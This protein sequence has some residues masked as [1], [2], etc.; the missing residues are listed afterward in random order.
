[1]SFRCLLVIPSYQE[2]E[3]LPRFLPALLEE[4]S[5]GNCTCDVRVVDDGSGPPHVENLK[6][7]CS[8]LQSRYSMLLNPLLLPQ[9]QGKGGAVRA[10]WKERADYS[11]VGFV[12]ADGAIPPREVIRLV[13][14]ARAHP[15]VS[16]MGSR[17]KMLG[18][19]IQ[20]STTRH[21]SGRVFASLVGVTI[22][23][24]VYDSQ[25]GIKLFPSK[26]LAA[27]EPWL[28]E[29]GFAFDVELLAA[30]LSAGAEIREEPIDWFDIPGSKVS[31]IR[32]VMRM[33]AAVLRIRERRKSWQKGS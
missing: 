29:S 19:T 21:L 28:H 25:C 4:L 32:D 26:V 8:D 27:I 24:D 17:I 13:S 1:M 6:A 12:D 23:S 31:M 30:L 9:N 16:F 7:L 10:G 5:A 20:R 14:L 18:K 3:R 2:S 22:S 11:T 33:T 15:D